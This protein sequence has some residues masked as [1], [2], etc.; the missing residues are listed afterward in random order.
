MITKFLTLFFLLSLTP[1]ATQCMEETAET[2][3][4]PCMQE[5]TDEQREN[6]YLFVVGNASTAL[7]LARLTNEYKSIRDTPL[8]A[9]IRNRIGAQCS[10]DGKCHAVASEAY[11]LFYS[12]ERL[13][14]ETDATIE[15]VSTVNGRGFHFT[16]KTPA[17]P[18]RFK[19]LF[20]RSWLITSLFEGKRAEDYLSQKVEESD[21]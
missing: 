6:Q 12:M 14:E 18:E 21:C 8:D 16:L 19:A 1:G 7:T 3:A 15:T 10:C 9:F 17:A 2:D 5:E 4:T 13:K 11:K 20:Q